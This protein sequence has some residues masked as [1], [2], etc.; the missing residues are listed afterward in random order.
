[1]RRNT[2]ILVVA[3]VAAACGGA[4]GAGGTTIANDTT[5]TTAP[6]E[7][8]D[9]VRPMLTISDEG[10][11]VPVE[12]N[13]RRVPRFVLMSDGTI[14][15]PAPTTLEFPGKAVPPIQ[16]GQV[17]AET[18]AG[19]RGLIDTSGLGEVTDESNDA[20]ASRVADASTTVFVYVD[21]DGGE[22]RFA[23][24][25]LGL[26]DIDFGDPRVEQLELLLAE[27]EQAAGSA[28]GTEIW[29]P[30]AVQVYVS[31][32]PMRFDPEF[33][34]TMEY[35]LDAGFDSLGEAETAGFQCLTLEGTEAT[36]LL[37]VMSEANEATTFVT[38]GGEEYTI[39]VKPLLPGQE[40]C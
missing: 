30:E 5:T 21:Q 6:L 22:H 27:V 7:G 34:N 23:V 13:L 28:T 33:S 2:L 26:S 38:E 24:Y 14:Y 35:P 40:G 18:L 15:S 1:M 31:D 11:F 3:L 37:D 36:S 8:P 25:A 29:Q 9:D 19:I 12:Y 10:G 20:A 17:D 32:Q 4:D 16:V 39:L